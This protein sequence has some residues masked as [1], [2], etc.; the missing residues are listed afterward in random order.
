MRDNMSEYHYAT[1]DNGLRV[2]SVPMPHHHSAEVIVYLGVGSRHESIRQA[3]ASHFLEHMLFKGSADYPTGLELERAFEALGGSA[4]AATDAE[5]T[6]FH[7][8]VHPEHVPLGIELFASMLRRPLFNGIE[9]ERRIILE[10]ALA[11]LSETGRQIN[12]DNLIAAL[13]F[14]DHPLGRPTLGTR[15]SIER[16]NLAGI[17]RHYEAFY[18]PRNTV[19]TVAGPISPDAVLK[20]ARTFF[21]EWDGSPSKPARPWRAEGKTGPE[22]RWVRDAGSQVAMQF[23]FRLPGRDND[24]AVNLRV[25]RRVLGW[26]GMSRLMMRLR[27][28]LGLTYAV[29]AGLALYAEVGLLAVDLAVSPENLPRATEAILQIFTEMTAEPIDHEELEHS[30]RSYRYDLQYSRDQVDEMALRYA[31]GTITGSMRTIAGDFADLEK[32]TAHGLQQTARR[33][34]VPGQLKA[35][36]VG[37]YR[38]TDRKAVEQLIAAWRP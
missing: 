33:L 27:E 36:F 4:N 1:L 38:S 17:R 25:W 18:T 15:T 29:D 23:A 14:P 35:A 12:P 20:A 19:L 16:L 6:C 24:H 31:W 30:L 28:E 34:F 9:V 26:G 3:G 11:D 5:T 10:E 37:P 7:S 8:R 21:A 2:V 22:V 13:L 32:V